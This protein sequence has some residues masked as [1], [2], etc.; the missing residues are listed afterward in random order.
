M[1]APILFE[2]EPDQ[3]AARDQHVA[4]D[5]R[6]ADARVPPDADAGHQNAVLDFAEA[7]HP[8]VRAQY[9]AGDRAAADDTARRD[10][11]VERLAAADALL[12]ED[13]LRRRR[14]RLIGAQRP[15]R[16]VEVEL[17]VHLTEI[18]VR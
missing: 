2:I 17:G 13:E 15:L 7:V 16:I 12:R 3:R 10:H 18:H 5:D 4:V 8:Y 14:L 6:P 11:R 1:A 9:A